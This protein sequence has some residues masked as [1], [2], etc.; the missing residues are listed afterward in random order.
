MPSPALT[1]LVPELHCFRIEAAAGPL[2][3]CLCLTFGLLP[4]QAHALTVLRVGWR[5]DYS[6]EG[7]LQALGSHRPAGRDEIQP[8]GYHSLLRSPRHFITFE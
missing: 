6:G 7:R 8:S 3:V 2:M 1:V 5:I 4:N